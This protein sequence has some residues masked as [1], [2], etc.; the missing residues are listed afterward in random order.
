V[1]DDP[2]KSGVSLLPG[3]DERRE[4][5]RISA[6][7]EVKYESLEEL[8]SAYTTDIS[9]G[10]IFVPTERFVPI[11]AVV[12]V[13]MRLPS[14]GTA[15]KAIARV[16][17]TTD[18]P[19]AGFAPRQR[20]MGME[21]LDVGGAPLANQIQRF[22]AETVSSLPP[23]ETTPLSDGLALVVDDDE[24]YR[25][26]ATKAL[27]DIGLEVIIAHN[28][29]DALGQALRRRPNVIVSDVNMPEMDGWQLLRLI[30][31][32]PSLAQIP[33]VFL[34]RL[35]SDGE[36]LMGYR[37]GVDDYVSKPFTAAELG[38]RVRRII[39]RARAMGGAPAN[40]ALRGDLSQVSLSSLLS[41]AEMERRTGVL[42]VLH[43]EERA[44]LQVREGSVVQITLDE[45]RSH[46]SAR[47]RFFYVLSWAV[48]TFELA[49]SEVAC[50]DDVC[51]KTSYVLLEHARLRDEGLL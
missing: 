27:Q 39:E 4:H 46:L 12:E 26:R 7:L 24:M 34:T 14:G 29:V 21:F 16:A 23:P 17:Y 38:A 43:G 2:D 37:L 11:G 35:T 3:D 8:V 40:Q 42:T 36:R 30:R 9:R 44:V 15:I 31:S 32:R 49:A 5:R 20:G 13:T 41:L 22:V 50:E 18:H 33:V 47:D 1:S 19:P 45:A 48:G 6:E 25:E 10:G 51:L 28:G